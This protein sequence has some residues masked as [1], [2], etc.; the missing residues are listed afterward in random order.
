MSKKE[1]LQE[2]E[3]DYLETVKDPNNM[4]IAKLI[5]LVRENEIYLIVWITH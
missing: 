5:N 2:L 3:K 4:P 1:L